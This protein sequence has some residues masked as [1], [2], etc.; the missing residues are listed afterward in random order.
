MTSA[1]EEEKIF[2]LVKKNRRTKDLVL[3]AC[4]S[5]YPVPIKDLN[6]LEI[7]RLKKKYGKYGCEIGFSGHY[8]GISV[9]N[10]AILLGA[11]WIERHFTLDRTWKGTDHAASLEPDGMRRL[12]V[13]LDDSLN[14]LNYK[15]KEI[16]DIEKFQRKKLKRFV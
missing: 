6:L 9:D 8:S 7:S 11:T 5:G 10:L 15:K 1:K 13:N 3:Y 12:Q 4:T 2:N 16:L 14:A